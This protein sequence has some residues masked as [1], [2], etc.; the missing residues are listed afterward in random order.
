MRTG[1]HAPV[2]AHR[3]APLCPAPPSRSV[4]I[5]QS[6]C[7]RDQSGGG[8]GWGGAW[9]LD[10]ALR[11]PEGA[12]SAGRGECGLNAAAASGTSLSP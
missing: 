11:P 1:G 9:R 3:C 6:A 10:P 12:A 2:A 4:P 5:G 8:G 7:A